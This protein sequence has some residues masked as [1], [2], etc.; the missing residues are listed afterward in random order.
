MQEMVTLM[1]EG[2]K[3]KGM[4][5]NVAKTKVMVIEKDDEM[6]ECKKD[7][8][9]ETVEQVSEFVY[10]GSVFTRDGK[11][12][13]D[14]KR[15]VNAGNQINGALHSFVSR[16]GISQ[17]ARLAVH[18]GVLAPTLMYGSECWAWK[19]QSESRIN[20]VEMRSLRSMCGVK[21]ID[22][23]RNEI[24]REECG[25]KEDIVTR[26]EKGML[27][28]FGHLERMDESRLTKGI[29]RVKVNG[30]VGRGRP[31]RTFSDQ[32]EHVLRKGHILST[33]NRRA[34]MTRCMNVEEAKEVCL[35]R[36]RWQTLVSAYPSGKQA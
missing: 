23:V 24:I 21:L 36:S 8:N 16:K 35:D 34:C 27:R 19:K 1:N 31:R 9:G 13:K 18:N 22:R 6:T 26:I 30:R 3:R 2:F 15:R 33:R 7:I 28:W 12:E 5:V 29:Y 14:V 11:I 17:K 25:L 10:L 4:K 32:I 20:A